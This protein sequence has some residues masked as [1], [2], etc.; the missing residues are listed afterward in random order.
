MA[1]IPVVTVHKWRAL[2]LKR[3]AHLLELR[4]SGR[5]RLHYASEDAFDAA[6]RRVEADAEQW[7]GLAYEFNPHAE[8]AE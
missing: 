4:R 2:A 6:L 3:L 5:W 7:K 8:A 1:R